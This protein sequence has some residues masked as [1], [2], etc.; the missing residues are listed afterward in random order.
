ML[1][2]EHQTKQS[3]LPQGEADVGAG[4]SGQASAEV[5]SALLGRAGRDDAEL[6][7]TSLGKGI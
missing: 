3:G 5:F 1:G 2:L 4:H 7:E 6:L